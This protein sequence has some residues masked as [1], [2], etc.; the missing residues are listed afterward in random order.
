[1][2]STIGGGVVMPSMRFSAMP[3]LARVVA[4]RAPASY[5]SLMR[6]MSSMDCTGHGQPRTALISPDSLR[7]CCTFLADTRRALPPWPP[8]VEYSVLSRASRPPLRKA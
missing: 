4:E 8:K 5:H 7:M 1:M 6:A 3:M 2:S